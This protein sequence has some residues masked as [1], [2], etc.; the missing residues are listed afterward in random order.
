[1]FGD[2]EDLETGEKFGVD[3]D[4]ATAT[5]MQAI[6]DEKKQRQSEKAAKKSV[7]DSE[8]DTGDKSVHLSY[9]NNS[10]YVRLC[11]L[12]W[13]DRSAVSLRLGMVVE[14]KC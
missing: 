7:F 8:Y 10:S 14:F 11:W 6:A 12:D 13:E 4:K 9:N 3:G 2:F 1:M 5:A